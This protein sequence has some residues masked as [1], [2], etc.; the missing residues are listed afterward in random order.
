V[1]VPIAVGVVAGVYGAEA[2]AVSE[3]DPSIER[4]KIRPATVS[5]AS[6]T[7]YRAARRDRRPDAW[8]MEVTPKNGQCGWNFGETANRT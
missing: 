6:G 3:E 5:T 8:C 2:S 1:L 4:P 7:R